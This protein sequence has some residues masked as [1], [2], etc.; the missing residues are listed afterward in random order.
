MKHIFKNCKITK[1]IE[2]SIQCPDQLDQPLAANNWSQNN[3]WAQQVILQNITPSQLH[4]VATK[5]TAEAVWK[6]LQA[7][8]KNKAHVTV[9]H[10]QRLI[11]GTKVEDSNDLVKHFKTMK[12]YHDCINQFPKEE[13]HITDTRFKSIISTSLPLSWINFVEPYNGNA[14]DPND[15]D[16]K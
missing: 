9:D 7:T 8:H 5:E 4:Y 10:L 13:F 1:Y 11:Y 14:Q 15:P 12:N 16:P 6:A 2:G 3:S